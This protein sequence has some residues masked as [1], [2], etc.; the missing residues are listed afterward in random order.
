MGLE[1]AK[2][3]NKSEEGGEGVL[4]LGNP[5]DGFDAKRMDGPE[6]GGKERGKRAA[7]GETEDEKEE[8]GVGRVKEDVGEVESPRA[9]SGSAEQQV[10]EEI[11]NPEEGGVHVPVGMEGGEGAE[12]GVPRPAIE[13]NRIVDNEDVVIV[14]EKG[15]RRG[16]P[17]K[18]ENRNKEKRGG[19]S[20]GKA[21]FHDAPRT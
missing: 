3:G 11:G 9:E 12:Q 18:S 2:D 16:R 20:D 1:I 15:K 4:A 8:E 14:L 21:V 6:G 5:C 7:G 17:E 10:V 13:H 19:E